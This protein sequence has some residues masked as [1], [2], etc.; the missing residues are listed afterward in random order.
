MPIVTRRTKRLSPLGKETCLWDCFSWWPYRLLLI[1]SRNTMGIFQH[2]RRVGASLTRM[3]IESRLIR[4]CCCH[5]Y[6]EES[7]VDGRQSVME[8]VAKVPQEADIMNS[9]G[10]LAFVELG[11][12]ILTARSYNIEHSDK[13]TRGDEGSRDES[14]LVSLQECE[15][16]Q[17]IQPKVRLNTLCMSKIIIAYIHPCGRVLL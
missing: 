3:E 7:P 11:T 9:N 5:W 17:A 14:R 8:E 2:V 1:V 10:R 4:L 16:F 15:I 6:V 12:T 13:R